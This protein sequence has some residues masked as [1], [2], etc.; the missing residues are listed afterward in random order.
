MVNRKVL[1]SQGA[2]ARG[3]AGFVGRWAVTKKRPG[4]WLRG[5]PWGA[6]AWCLLQ[7][8]ANLRIWAGN[9]E[10]LQGA[11]AFAGASGL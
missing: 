10:L 4:V 5:C 9:Y 7:C 8:S 11:G 3:A 2:V 1:C 6:I